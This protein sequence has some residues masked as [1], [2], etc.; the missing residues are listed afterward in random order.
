MVEVSQSGV[1]RILII[2][3]SLRAARLSV[4]M[5]TMEKISGESHCRTGE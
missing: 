1:M 3:C 4:R 2:K 5:L